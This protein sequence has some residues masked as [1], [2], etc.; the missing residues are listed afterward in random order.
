MT[1]Y[2]VIDNKTGEISA[3]TSAV[4]AA[5]LVGI[6]RLTLYRNAGNY[7]KKGFTVRRV[8]VQKIKGRGRKDGSNSYF[9]KPTD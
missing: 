5:K 9:A 4:Q 8:T 2:V 1:I 6:T 3:F 7:N